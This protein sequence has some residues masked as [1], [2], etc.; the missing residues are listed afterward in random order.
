M[1]YLSDSKWRQNCAC[2]G[3]IILFKLNKDKDKCIA[4]V[5]LWSKKEELHCLHLLSAT[6]YALS[7]RLH[8][9]QQTPLQIPLASSKWCQTAFLGL[10]GNLSLGCKIITSA[11]RWSMEKS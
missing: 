7:V 1:I 9:C 6:F 5:H 8:L 11:N 4:L 2:L 3:A 10:T